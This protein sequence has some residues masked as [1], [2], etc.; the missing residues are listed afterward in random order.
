MSEHTVDVIK[1]EEITPHNNADNLEI[2]KI[3]GYE[4]IVRKGQFKVGDLAV[5]VQPDYVVSLENP[6]FSFLR[7]PESSKTLHRV[8]VARFRGLWSQGLLIPAQEGMAE[9][10]NVMEKLGITRWEP[11]TSSKGTS[12]GGGWLGGGLQESGPEF[13]MPK[14]DLESLQKYHRLIPENLDVVL[15]AK[16]HGSSA[17]FCF[18]EG[19]MFYG[20]R[21]TWKKPIEDYLAQPVMFTLGAKEEADEVERILREGGTTLAHHVQRDSETNV[22]AVVKSAVL[23][24]TG[25]KWEPKGEQRKTKFSTA[26]H[27]AC[28]DNPWIEEWCKAHPGLV[29]YGE[30]YGFRVQGINFSYGKTPEEV[31]FAVFDIFLPEENGTAKWYNHWEL[32]EPGNELTKG[33]Q[34]VPLLHCGPFNME[35]VK[36]LAEKDEVMGTNQI[37]EGVVVKPKEE[38]YNGKIGR[39]ALKYVGNRYYQKS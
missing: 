12:S 18:S 2:V 24:T 27:D 14:Y 30:I 3:W 39:V 17:R 29:L 19:R 4:C 9:G 31:G 36:E 15:T 20:S 22:F 37:R 6:V 7:K 35:M 21:T 26:W 13:D 1:I 5:F 23:E 16:I 25:F 11:G 28:R 38:L 34:L 10:D 8:T 33:L 32:H